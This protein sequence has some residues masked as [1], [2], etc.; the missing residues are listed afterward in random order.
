MLMGKRLT[1][2]RSVVS[3]I[4]T[5]ELR[6]AER[7]LARLV[8]AAYAADNPKL[9]RS[10]EARHRER[11]YDSAADEAGRVAIPIDTQT[12]VGYASTQSEPPVEA[13]N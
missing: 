4:T 1:F 10:K 6:S 12:H 8:A 5:E 9:F 7:T 11:V 2:E 3:Q 13:N